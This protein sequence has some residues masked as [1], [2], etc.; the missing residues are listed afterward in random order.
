AVFFEVQPA[1]I[2]I[3]SAKSALATMD[4]RIEPSIP[5]A[6]QGPRLLAS[7]VTRG[8]HRRC[9]PCHGRVPQGWSQ[10]KMGGRSR[11]PIAAAATL[12]RRPLVQG[13]LVIGAGA[14]RRRRRGERQRL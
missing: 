1:S 9:D 11:P 13:W 14:A 2:R 5:L 4:L 6:Y 10:S 7:L 12:L 8:V 3:V